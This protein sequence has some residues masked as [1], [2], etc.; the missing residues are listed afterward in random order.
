MKPE[1][2][3]VMDYA[4]K[5]YLRRPPVC[6]FSITFHGTSQE[7]GIQKGQEARAAKAT[8]D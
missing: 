4:S 6:H 3:F 8:A 5:E 7:G 1:D 2:L